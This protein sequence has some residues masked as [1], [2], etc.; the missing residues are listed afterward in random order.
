MMETGVFN[1]RP[2]VREGACVQARP[3]SFLSAPQVNCFN[4]TLVAFPLI[5]GYGHMPT[6]LEVWF[7]FLI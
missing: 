7:L 4:Q 5:G 1:E 6:F 3:P 2:C